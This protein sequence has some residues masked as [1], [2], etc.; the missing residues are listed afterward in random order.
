MVSGKPSNQS[1]RGVDIPPTTR[2][3]SSGYLCST[4]EIRVARAT[5]NTGFVVALQTYVLHE[6][7]AYVP[8]VACGGSDPRVGMKG[9]R[10]L[11]NDPV[12]FQACELGL[13]CKVESRFR[14]RPPLTMKWDC[15]S[16]FPHRVTRAILWLSK[17]MFDQRLYHACLVIG[18]Y[19][20]WIIN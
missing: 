8:A 17:M 9:K 10:L 4:E 11:R 19:L 16:P 6:W 13:P 12:V 1:A 2:F 15:L 5:R 3:A 14:N 7:C 18:A 20:E